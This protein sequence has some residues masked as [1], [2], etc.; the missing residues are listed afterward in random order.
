MTVYGSIQL[1]KTSTNPKQTSPRV[2]CQHA[3]EPAIIKDSFQRFTTRLQ[4]SAQFDPHT[5]DNSTFSFQD[6]YQFTNSI[7]HSFQLSEPI[8]E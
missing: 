4:A 5:T 7:Y 8:Q 1:A 2:K 6:L 3:Y